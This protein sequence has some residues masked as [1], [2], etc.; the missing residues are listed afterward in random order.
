MGYA[1]GKRLAEEGCSVTLLDIKDDPERAKAINCRSWTVDLID[2]S[3]IEAT[4]KEIEKQLGPASILVNSAARFILKG[5]DASP[6]DWDEM[7]HVNIRGASFM[8]K[9]VVPQMEQCGHGSIVNFS[10]VSGFVGQ[11]KFSTYTA[12]KFAVRGLTQVLA[13]ELGP[14]GIQVNAIC[15][16]TIKGDRMKR[17]IRDKAK[18]TKIS[19]KKIENDFVSMASIK[20]WISEEDVG[21]MCAHLISDE[22]NKISGQ[23]IAVDG[24]AE[25]MD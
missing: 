15:P 7:T 9:Y 17:V 6:E 11:P 21:N 1:A 4:C 14:L 23:I 10:S 22:A 25:R 5:I 13:K 18:F 20:S 2:E 19:P 12:T 3:A 8:A 16:G 24:N